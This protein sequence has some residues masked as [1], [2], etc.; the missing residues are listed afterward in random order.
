MQQME[1]LMLDHLLD[2]LLMLDHLLD[3]LLDLMHMQMEEKKKNRLI[4]Y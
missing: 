3:H 2:H 4:R 1:E